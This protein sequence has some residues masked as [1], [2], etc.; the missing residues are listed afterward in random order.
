MRPSDNGPASAALVRG[1]SALGG[2]GP[3]GQD[4]LMQRNVTDPGALGWTRMTEL[5][6]AEALALLARTRLGRVVFSHQALPAVRPVNFALVG[7]DVCFRV[8]G[9]STMRRALD[10]NIVAFEAD[11][12]DL[13]RRTGW[14]VVITGPAEIVGPGPEYDAMTAALPE[15][16]APGAYDS[17]VRIRA[18][19]V[20]GRRISR[21]DGGTANGE[22]SQ[23]C[24]SPPGPATG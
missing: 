7:A 10:G 13:D 22:S 21:A 5:E 9:D 20:T 14:S 19:L 11:D 12:L 24:P 6:R 3:E 8:R 18:Q 4:R 23:F 17:V 15:P 16:W 1:R 2:D